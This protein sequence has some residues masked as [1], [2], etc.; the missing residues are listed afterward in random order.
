MKFQYR[1]QYL[2]DLQSK[3]S[4]E[5]HQHTVQLK[6]NPKKPYLVGE[7]MIAPTWCFFIG[8]SRRNN[9]STTGIK[10]DNV[11]PLPVTAST[12]TSLCAM[13]RGIA[14]ACTGVIRE[15]PMEETASRTHSDSGGVTPSQALADPPE[16]GFG[17]IPNKQREELAL[18]GCRV[19]TDEA[20]KNTRKKKLIRRSPIRY[21][22]AVRDATRDHIR[23]WAEKTKDGF[24]FIFNALH[25]TPF[26]RL[27]SC[28]I[29]VAFILSLSAS[30]LN[31]CVDSCA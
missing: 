30:V 5:S 27:A 29:D 13:N 31:S 3:F 19:A 7:I 24:A 15:K 22:R 18:L 6:R 2:V 4:S 9:F 12:T 1:E 23:V 16:G 8:S 26:A 28:R 17:A 25:S 20:Q 11:F 21:S 14:D 10:N